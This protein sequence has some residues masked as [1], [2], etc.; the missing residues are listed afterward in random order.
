MFVSRGMLNDLVECVEEG[1]E[2][3]RTKV[4]GRVQIHINMHVIESHI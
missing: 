4:S 3:L 1:F 2:Q